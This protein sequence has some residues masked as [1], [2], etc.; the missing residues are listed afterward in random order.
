MPPVHKGM[1]HLGQ[2]VLSPFKNAI[3]LPGNI[4]QDLVSGWNFH[5]GCGSFQVYLKGR[6]YKL[7]FL[8]FHRDI[9]ILKNHLPQIKGSWA[10]GFQGSMVL[11]SAPFTPPRGP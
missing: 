11:T 4:E 5:R 9:V 1:I 7:G 2:E 10:R 6:R 8:F 3:M